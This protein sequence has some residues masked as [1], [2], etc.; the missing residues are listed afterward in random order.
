MFPCDLQN[1]SDDILKIKLNTIRKPLRATQW[2]KWPKKQ[3]EGV[4]FC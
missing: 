4:R 1:P 3:S 2:A